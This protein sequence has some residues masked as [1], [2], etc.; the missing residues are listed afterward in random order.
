M[1]FRKRWEDELKLKKEQQIVCVAS[2]FRDVPGPSG[3][4]KLKNRYFEGSEQSPYS[5]SKPLK[6]EEGGCVENDG[7]AGEGG[8]ALAESEDQ[9]EYVTIARGLLDG[10]TGPLLDRIQKERTRRKRQ[11]HNVTSAC[12]TILQLERP[13]RK[14]IKDE[15]LVDQFIQDLV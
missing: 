10:R 2:P 8:E 11:F 1:A 12:S 14:V 9:P 3:Q 15:K 4:R 13:Q 6:P 7:R 5:V